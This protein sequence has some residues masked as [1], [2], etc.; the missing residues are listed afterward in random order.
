[1]EKDSRN[2]RAIKF[3][4]IVATTFAFLPLKA[5]TSFMEGQEGLFF[6]LFVFLP[7]L[8]IYMWTK[9]TRKEK[10]LYAFFWLG[11]FLAIFLVLG[12]ML[13]SISGL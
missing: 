5:N 11:P 12:L 6:L 13:F 3:G 2:I 10:A 9:G 1:M 8:I 4:L 7:S